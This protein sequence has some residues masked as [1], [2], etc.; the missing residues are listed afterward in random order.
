MLRW[1][2]G[3]SASEHAEGGIPWARRALRGAVSPAVVLTGLSHD[4]VKPPKRRVTP[5]PARAPGEMVFSGRAG[6]CP[7][8]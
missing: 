2:S 6:R 4:G 7:G 1:I 3:W 8:K 5:D